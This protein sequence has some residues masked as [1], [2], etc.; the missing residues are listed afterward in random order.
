MNSYSPIIYKYN[1]LTSTFRNRYMP[2]Q[3]KLRTSEL[4][5]NQDP[6]DMYE[7][8]FVGKT[9]C[10]DDGNAITT[11]INATD[12]IQKYAWKLHL[13]YDNYEQ[14]WRPIQYNSDYTQTLQLDPLERWDD[15]QL[16][17]ATVVCDLGLPGAEW[18]TAYKVETFLPTKERLRYDVQ[19]DPYDYDTQL[20]NNIVFNYNYLTD[21]MPEYPYVSTDNYW[22]GFDFSTDRR[23]DKS[24]FNISSRSDD[25]YTYQLNGYGNF[26]TY[27]TLAAMLHGN[28]GGGVQRWLGDT[29]FVRVNDTKTIAYA[30]MDFDCQHDYYIGWMLPTGGWFSY[31]FD[32]KHLTSRASFDK[33]LIQTVYKRERPVATTNRYS[34]LLT[35]K[36]K[37][38][39]AKVLQTIPMTEEVYVYDVK[40][41]V[42]VWCNPKNTS[43]ELAA[44]GM[45]DFDVELEIADIYKRN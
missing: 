41:D 36:V 7:T 43:Y 2:Y 22:V 6:V 38:D 21:V 5:S 3:I 24:Y 18:R 27:L 26:S 32:E 25:H 16:L 35:R 15:P 17:N 40:N 34:F 13:D 12:I 29:V 30:H 9:W 31:G 10:N 37:N 1:N 8:L 28:G 20:T 4:D 42:G 11:A 19:L 14:V 39:V 33:D 23:S 45:S 44:K